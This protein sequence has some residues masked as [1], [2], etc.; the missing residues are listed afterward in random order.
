MHEYSGFCSTDDDPPAKPGAEW[1][2]RHEMTITGRDDVDIKAIV[3][4]DYEAIDIGP[5]PQTGA[6]VTVTKVL[7]TELMDITD[8]VDLEAIEQR[9]WDKEFA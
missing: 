5:D 7:D 6:S 3:H 4:A 2:D 8:D 1:H 9:L